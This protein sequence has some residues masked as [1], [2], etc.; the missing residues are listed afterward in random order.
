MTFFLESDFVRPIGL[1]E[2]LVCSVSRIFVESNILLPVFDEELPV[3]D[4]VRR[5]SVGHKCA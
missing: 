2:V 4:S 5:V 3:V 1:P